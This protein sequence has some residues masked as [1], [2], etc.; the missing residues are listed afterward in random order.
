M[1][2][3]SGLMACHTTPRLE[4]LCA[5]LSGCKSVADIGCDHAYLSILLA[6]ADKKVRIIATDLREGPLLCARENIKRFGLSDR[7][8]TRLG[9]GLEPI[10]PGECEA[11]A[12]AGM[13]A[14][15]ICGILRADEQAAKRARL[16]V[17]QPM[18]AAPDLRRYLYENGYTIKQEILVR[19]DR[20]IYTILLAY[21]GETKSYAELD[22]YISP[23][24]RAF[25]PPLYI[26][27][28]KKLYKQCQNAA[29]GMGKAHTQNCRLAGY[30]RLADELKQLLIDT[31]DG[32]DEVQRNSI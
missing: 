7:I 5:A 17:L 4:A 30:E 12:A 9:N 22:C 15:A 16:L 24:L 23:A 31:G 21:G 10:A 6:R 14:N 11:I 29:E 3:E 25:R 18:S 1:P 19:E 26:S 32:N 8:E 13:G 2:D 27:Y 20:R 28:V